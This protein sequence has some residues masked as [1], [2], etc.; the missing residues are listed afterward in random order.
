M[1]NVLAR[2]WWAVGLR[3]LAA[4]IFGIL[5]LVVPHITLF[6]LII[7]FGAYALVNGAFAIFVAIRGR[8]TMRNWVWLLV[9]GVAGVLLGILTL[10]WPQVTALVLLIFI[11]AWALVTGFGEIIQAIELRKIISNEWLLVL[12]GVLSILFGLILLIFPSAGALGLLYIIGIYAIIFGGLLMA[13]SWQLR[14]M[15]KAA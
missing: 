12:S 9:E 10:R 13:L 3:G 2:H 6:V 4:V 14:S 1:L 11:A 7:F 15:R 5:T 8:E